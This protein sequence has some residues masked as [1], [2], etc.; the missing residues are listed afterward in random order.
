MVSDSKKD[1]LEFNSISELVS[2]IIPTYNHANFL[3]KTLK[4]VINQ[5]Y[6]NW[7]A[8][9]IDNHSKDN[10]DEVVAKFKDSRIILYKIKNNGIIAKSRNLGIEHAN[11][12]WIAF[13]DADD[14]W[15]PDK[16]KTCL[17]L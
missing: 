9:V 16:L 1:N 5:T 2:V 12:K 11:G 6:S 17:N 15:Y 8:I 14:W 13:L 3:S 7:E 4:S 10:T